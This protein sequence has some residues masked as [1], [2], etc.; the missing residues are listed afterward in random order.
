[1]T[2][3][4]MTAPK[5]ILYTVAFLIS[6]ATAWALDTPARSAMVLDV[7][8]GT[9]LFEKDAD[10]PIPPASMSKLMTLNLLFEAIKD[11]RVSMDTKFVVSQKAHKMGGSKMFLRQ[12]E[13]VSVENL[14]NGI[15]IQSGNDACIVVAEG[16]AGSEAAFAIKMTERA[17]KLGMDNS[18]FANSTGWPDPNQRMSAHDLVFLANRLI[19]EFPEYYHFFS[20]KSFTWSKVTQANRNPLLKLGI[21]AD[22]LKTGHTQEAGYGLVGSAVQGGRRV[23]FMITGLGSSAERASEAERITNWAF[24]NFITRT[25]FKKGVTI[26]SADVFLGQQDSVELYA[27]SNIEALIPYDAKDSLKAAITYH[28]P[29]KAPISKDSQIAHLRVEAQGI[30][31]FSVPLYAKNAVGKA[32][33]FKRMKVSAT[34][35]S[36]DILGNS[37]VK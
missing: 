24:R 16:L 4:P 11:N 17:K 10:R 21:G 33:F 22:G 6:T 28:G 35:L 31:P 27:K 30:K 34:V 20:K 36:N 7:N 9:V 37:D 3:A 1:M 18:H 19:T 15:I 13:R 2:A 14:I 25:V 5:V 8:T 29:L 23:I 12:G 26:G 32:G